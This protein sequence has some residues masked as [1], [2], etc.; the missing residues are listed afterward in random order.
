M[1]LHPSSVNCH[2][3]PFEINHCI[4]LHFSFC[5]PSPRYFYGRT[6][7]PE[8]NLLEADDRHVTT[9]T[10][11]VSGGFFVFP[12]DFHFFSSGGQKCVAKTENRARPKFRKSDYVKAVFSHACSMIR[13]DDGRFCRPLS[14]SFFSIISHAHR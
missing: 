13:L 10:V 14:C 6:L 3:Q 9:F 12:P 5:F 7:E 2:F 1:E 8:R 4:F 11:N